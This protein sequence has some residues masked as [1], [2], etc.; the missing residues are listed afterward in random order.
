MGFVFTLRS[1]QKMQKVDARHNPIQSEC[2]DALLLCCRSIC[3]RENRQQNLICIAAH[4][5]PLPGTGG[6]RVHVFCGAS[7]AARVEIF[8]LFGSKRV[9]TANQRSTAL[10]KLCFASPSKLHPYMHGMPSRRFVT[11]AHF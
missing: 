7:N 1:H 3:C 10:P 8:Q 9:M 6:G 11:M 4:P 5:C 2:R